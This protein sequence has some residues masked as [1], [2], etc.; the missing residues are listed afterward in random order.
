MYDLYEFSQGL[1]GVAEL[2]GTNATGGLVEPTVCVTGPAV[3]PGNVNVAIA[4]RGGTRLSNP[5]IS[6]CGAASG[7]YDDGADANVFRRVLVVDAYV[8]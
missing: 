1:R 3:T 2:S 4:W 7:R 8:E 6:T 5:A